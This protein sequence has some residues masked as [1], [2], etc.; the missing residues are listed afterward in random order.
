MYLSGAGGTIWCWREVF[1]WR[2]S[3]GPSQ[4][5]PRLDLNQP[6]NTQFPATITALY[7]EALLCSEILPE[8]LPGHIT[9]GW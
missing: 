1:S 7:G 3:V 8:E 2:P 4:N 5:E 6:L 9:E